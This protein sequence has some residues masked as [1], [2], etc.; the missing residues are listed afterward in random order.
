MTHKVFDLAEGCDRLVLLSRKSEAGPGKSMEEISKILPLIFKGQAHR[1][2]PPVLDILAPLWPLVAGKPM[3]RH[4][5]P[6]GFQEG[7]LILECDCTAWSTEMRHMS[8]AILAQVNRYLGVP[9]VR[10][11][12]IS[13]V[14]KLSI[15]MPQ[16]DK[17]QVN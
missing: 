10:K 14:P 11:L 12:K 13:Y 8:D 3:A 1:T 15:A 4:S 5:R 17:S 16:P 9:A 2:N 6:V 7:T